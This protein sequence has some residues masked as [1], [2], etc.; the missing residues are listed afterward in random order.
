MSRRETIPDFDPQRAVIPQ[1]AAHLAEHGD[2]TVDPLLGG[3]LQ[4]DLLVDAAG[5]APTL[6]TDDLVMGIARRVP[7]R[8][9]VFLRVVESGH[10][11]LIGSGDA[12]VAVGVA[13]V[14]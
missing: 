7:E 9:F 3:F 10:A 12:V 11:A 2:Q 6:A 4:P 1:D 8:V 13:A 5:T 14:P